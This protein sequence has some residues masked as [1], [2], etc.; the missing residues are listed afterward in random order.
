MLEISVRGGGREIAPIK[1]RGSPG[2]GSGGED[3][4]DP[5]RL[6]TSVT[7][8]K[9]KKVRNRLGGLEEAAEHL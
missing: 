5:W 8:A 1:V 7:S 9:R 2:Q 3:A 6:L 4:C